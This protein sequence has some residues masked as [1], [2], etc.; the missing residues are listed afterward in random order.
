MAIVG[1]TGAGKSTIVQLIPRL[2]DVQKGEILVDDLPITQ[3]TQKSLRES[4]AF[5][6]QKPFLF[7]DTVK[8]NIALLHHAESGCSHLQTS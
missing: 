2:Y 6:S 1:P 8:A 7:L 3:Y 4:I 5:V